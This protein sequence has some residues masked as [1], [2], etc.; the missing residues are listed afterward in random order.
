MSAP[1]DAETARTTGGDH[2]GVADCSPRAWLPGRAR[3]EPSP[4]S[5]FTTVRVE[6][7]RTKVDG[8]KSWRAERLKLGP[9]PAELW[10]EAIALA[11]EVGVARVSGALEMN[12]GALSRRVDPQRSTRH[13]PRA[14][15][16]QREF[17]EVSRAALPPAKAVSTII[18]LTSASGG[19]LTVR[20]SEPVDVGLLLSQFQARQ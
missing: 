3:A 10:A 13:R 9:M 11:G 19:R 16:A 1:I 12:H 18:E 17:V 5:D 7:G 8:V 6:E 14:S 15:L 20:L 4:G 2:P